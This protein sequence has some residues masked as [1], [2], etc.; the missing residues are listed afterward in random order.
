[1]ESFARISRTGVNI[2]CGSRDGVPSF[3]FVHVELPRVEELYFN[4]LVMKFYGRRPS[5]EASQRKI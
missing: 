1:M 5:L 3:S 2:I 4:A